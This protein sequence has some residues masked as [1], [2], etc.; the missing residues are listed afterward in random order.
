MADKP[1]K[2]GKEVDRDGFVSVRQVAEKTSLSL[3]TIYKAIECGQLIAY[4]LMGKKCMRP[5]DVERWVLINA[6]KIKGVAKNAGMQN[7]AKRPA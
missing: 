3:A 5:A 4:N 1:I 2:F 7:R 6:I